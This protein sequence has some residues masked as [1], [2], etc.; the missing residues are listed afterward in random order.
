MAQ[1]LARNGVK[2]TMWVR[3]K[4]VVES[5]NKEHR[6][7]LFLKDIALHENITATN[8]FEESMKG[9]QIIMIVIPTPFLREVVCTRH[10]SIPV[11]VPLVCC[12]KG[13]ENETLLTPFEILTEE[14]PGKYHEY[15]AAVSGPS[16]AREVAVGMPTSVLCA[17]NNPVVGETIQHT[18][19]DVDFRV[20]TGNDVIGAEICGAVKNVIAIACGASSGLGFGHDTMALL[21]T[22]G[23]GEITKLAIM[24]GAHPSTMS[25]LAG[26]GD[27]VLTCTSTMS[28]NYSVGQRIAKGEKLNEIIS[29]MKMVAEGVK[30]SKSVHMMCQQL[31][32]H[33]PLC[34][35]VY[36]V[37]HEDK[38]LSEA[39]I[40]L[41]QLPLEPEFNPYEHYNE[42][43]EMKLDMVQSRL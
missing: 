8:N 7:H 29:K 17:S 39:L 20:F 34:E 15:L 32:M 6:N 43:K 26:I 22:R 2:V 35:E 12:T 33:L 42:I 40:D 18:M 36:R 9:S 37:L 5:I 28:R 24:K 31:G 19:S 21:I 23:L 16:F 11:G 41:G 38:D 10:S 27:L 4:E 3:E 25:G 1:V 14:L 13:I 30:T